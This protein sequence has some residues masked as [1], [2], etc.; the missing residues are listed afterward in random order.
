MY[1]FFVK[2]TKKKKRAVQGRDSWHCK[3]YQRLLLWLTGSVFWW[4]LR[5]TLHFIFGSQLFLP[6][7]FLVVKRDWFVQWNVKRLTNMDTD[8]HQW[9]VELCLLWHYY[10]HTYE[11]VLCFFS[12]LNYVFKLRNSVKNLILSLFLI[13]KTFF[14]RA[15]CLALWIINLVIYGSHCL[16]YLINLN[17]VLIWL[18]N[19]Y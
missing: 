14:W 9:H 10:K 17:I 19:S 13:L 7:I 6:Q 8:I 15:F 16:G 1:F 3:R 11:L 2:L 12:L 4:A 18:R 5:Q